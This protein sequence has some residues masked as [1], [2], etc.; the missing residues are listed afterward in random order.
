MRI[1]DMDNDKPITNVLLLLTPSEARQMTDFM[2]ILNSSYGNHIH[3]NDDDLD[4]EITIAVST[5]DNINTF[6]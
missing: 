1:L 4:H 3:V 5:M 2:G 6:D